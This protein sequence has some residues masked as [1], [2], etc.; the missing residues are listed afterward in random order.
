MQVRGRSIVIL[1]MARLEAAAAHDALLFSAHPP[2][3]AISSG[4]GR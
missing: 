2:P 1:D 3:R 4:M